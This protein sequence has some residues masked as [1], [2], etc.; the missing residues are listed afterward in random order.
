MSHCHTCMDMASKLFTFI[1]MRRNYFTDKA[2]H[3]H[4][5]IRLPAGT[6]LAHK[7]KENKPQ[8]SETGVWLLP[9][10]S[11]FKDA[12]TSGGGNQAAVHRQQA[13]GTP[14]ARCAAGSVLADPPKLDVHARHELA[15]RGNHEPL[16]DTM[17]NTRNILGRSHGCCVP[18]HRVLHSRLH[19]PLLYSLSATLNCM[20]S[21][22][23]LLPS[24]LSP[25]PHCI[26]LHQASGRSHAC[27]VAACPCRSL[28]PLVRSCSTIA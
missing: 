9:S 20:L 7:P 21:C 14:R 19:L 16:T 5:V 28:A 12:H 22:H 18:A 23:Y 3:M 26:A 6:S 10:T 25:A 4:E 27:S 24:R 15:V 1:Y 13:D 11:N 8:I 17:A 2:H